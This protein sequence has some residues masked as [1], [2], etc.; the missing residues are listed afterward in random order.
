MLMVA[1][2]NLVNYFD[3]RSYASGLG[4]VIGLII[5]MVYLKLYILCSALK[6]WMKG[7]TGF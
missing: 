5:S 6:S 1:I 4:C 7:V 3:K 2:Y